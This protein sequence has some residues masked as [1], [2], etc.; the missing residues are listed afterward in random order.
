MKKIFIMCFLA[1]VLFA[2]ADKSYLIKEYQE[3][4]QKISQKRLGLDERAIAQVQPPF[5]KVVKK[6]KQGNKNSKGI[7][8]S[9]K[10]ILVLDAILGNKVMINGKWYKL[11]QKVGD[12]K[13]VA[14]RGDDVFLRG[15]GRKEKL[16]IRTKNANITIK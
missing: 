8:K 6:K 14:I 16:T 11:Y 1:T 10:K 3:M 15:N 4:F 5:V 9:A 7:K 13:I 2:N 12:L